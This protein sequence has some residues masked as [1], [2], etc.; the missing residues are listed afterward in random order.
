MVQYP[1]RENDLSSMMGFVR[2]NIGHEVHDIGRNVAPWNADL[3]F[4]PLVESCL[5]KLNHFLVALLEGARQRCRRDAS[6]IDAS[7]RSDS[8]SSPDH[9]DPHASRIVNMA[10]EHSDGAPRGSGYFHSPQFERKVFEEE[11]SHAVVRFPALDQSIAKRIM[12][13]RFF[14]HHLLMFVNE[15]RIDVSPGLRALAKAVVAG[16]ACKDRYPRGSLPSLDAEQRHV[17]NVF[18]QVGIGEPPCR[19]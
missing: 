7:R 5:Q 13:N 1:G 3:E 4:S 9:L 18:V 17:I 6:S 11:F 2:G 19:V 10:C 8:V 15:K 14:G 16:P 12:K